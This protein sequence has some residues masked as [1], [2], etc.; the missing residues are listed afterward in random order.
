MSQPISVPT[1][2]PSTSPESQSQSS[3]HGLPSSPPPQHST[4]QSFPATQSS[5]PPVA[6]RL[7]IRAPSASADN[8][9]IKFIWPENDEAARSFAAG[10]P[11]EHASADFSIAPD[12]SFVET[13]SG[14]AAMELKRKYDSELGRNASMKTPYAITAFINQHGRRMFRI[15][16]RDLSAPATAGHTAEDQIINRASSSSSANPHG[17][18]TS[19][20][21]HVSSTTTSSRRRSGRL[22][23]FLRPQQNSNGSSSTTTR[24][25]YYSTKNKNKLRKPRSNPDLQQ[26]Q[27]LQA[28]SPT[29]PTIGLPPYASST[30]PGSM[31]KKST[32]GRTHS[33]SVTAIDRQSPYSHSH[34]PFQVG[35]F[36]YTAPSSSTSASASSSQS[37]FDTLSPPRHPHQS[38][39]GGMQRRGDVFGEV[40]NW[41]LATAGHGYA[42]GRNRDRNNSTTSSMSMAATAGGS[43]MSPSSLSSS[44]SSSRSSV[45][46]AVGEFGEVIQPHDGG[47]RS[48]R[49]GSNATD[50]STSSPQI[51]HSQSS[52]S[53]SQS[54]VIPRPFG[55]NVT[56]EPRWRPKQ[57]HQQHQRGRNSVSNIYRGYGYGDGY[58]TPPPPVP[59]LPSL[60]FGPDAGPS[61]SNGVGIG[62]P[63]SNRTEE[64]RR[65]SQSWSGVGADADSDDMTNNGTGLSKDTGYVSESVSVDGEEEGRE[66]FE[67]WSAY[68]DTHIPGGGQPLSSF[69]TRLNGVGGLG[70][71]GKKKDGDLESDM[72]EVH[73]NGDGG[74]VDDTQGDGTNGKGKAPQ[75]GQD[76]EEESD[77]SIFLRQE[78]MSSR[79]RAMPS[80]DSVMTARQGQG[81]RRRS[82]SENLNFRVRR[83]RVGKVDEG[84]EAYADGE[85]FDEDDDIETPPRPPSAIRMRRPEQDEPPKTDGENQID[86]QNQNQNSPSQAHQ[87]PAIHVQSHSISSSSSTSTSTSTSTPSDSDG[88]SVTIS[89]DLHVDHEFPKTPTPPAAPTA[90]HQVH[91]QPLPTTARHTHFSTEVFDVLQTY[92]GLPLLDRLEKQKSKRRGSRRRRGRPSGASASASSASGAEEEDGDDFEMDGEDGRDVDGDVENEN[93][94][95]DDNDDDGEDE[96]VIKLSLEDDESAAPR[97]DPRFVIWG[98]LHESN[99]DEDDGVRSSSNVSQVAGSTS[100]ASSISVGGGSESVSLPGGGRSRGGSLSKRKVKKELKKKEKEARSRSGSGTAGVGVDGIPL[101]GSS[102]S[103]DHG[104]EPTPAAPTPTSQDDGKEKKKQL[105]AATIERWLAQVTSEFNYDELLVFFLTYRTYISP[106]DLAHLFICRFHW[107]VSDSEYGASGNT[108]PEVKRVVRLRTFVAFKF[109]L[110][111]F[112]VMD[113]MNNRELRVLL[114]K[115][116]NDFVKDPI[117]ERYPDALVSSLFHLTT[118]CYRIDQLQQNIVKKLRKVAKECK[119]AWVP[120]PPK[121]SQASPTEA[122]G[123]GSN[124]TSPGSAASSSLPTPDATEPPGREHL[125]GERF[126]EAALALK[127]TR[128]RKERDEDSDVDLDFVPDHVAATAAG[129]HIQ[130]GPTGIPLSSLSILQ[131]TDL[132]PGP[133]SPDV[134]ASMAQDISYQ[135]LPPLHGNLLSKVMG[136]LGKFKRVLKDHRTMG[137]MTTYGG[138]GGDGSGIAPIGS[139]LRGYPAINIESFSRLAVADSLRSPT[140]H[141]TQQAPGVLVNAPSIST[142]RNTETQAPHTQSSPAAPSVEAQTQDQTQHPISPTTSLSVSVAGNQPSEGSSTEDS[143]SLKVPST[144]R[145][146]DDT[147]SLSSRTSSI[148]LARTSSTDSFGVPLSATRSSAMFPAFRSPWQFDV[149]SLDELSDT[150]SNEDGEHE[151]DPTLPPGL[152][153]AHS[154]FNQHQNRPQRRLP[155]RRIMEVTND[156]RGTVSSMGI[157]SRR[158]HASTASTS[159]IGGEED[160]GPGLGRGIQQWQLN[161]LVDSLTDNEEPGDVEDALKRLEGHINPDKVL[162]KANKVEG[163][164]RTIRDKLQ[165]GDYD[166]DERPRWM[167]EDD[168]EENEHEREQNT[169]A[170]V[171]GEDSAGSAFEQHIDGNGNARVGEGTG[172]EAVKTPVGAVSPPRG[173]VTTDAKPAPEDVVPIEILQSR[174]SDLPSL[175]PNRPSIALRTSLSARHHSFVLDSKADVLAQYFAVIDRDLFCALGFDELLAGDWMS[176]NEIEVYSWKQ[177]MI[178][179]ARWRAESRYPER[180][181][182]LGNIRARFNLVANFAVSEVVHTHPSDRVHVFVKLLHV[183]WRSYHRNNLNN[184]VAIITGLQSTW[185]EQAM[186]RSI[187]RLSSWDARIFRDL[188]LYIANTNCFQYLREAIERIM[189]AKTIDT[190]GHSSSVV[191]GAHVDQSGRNRGSRGTAPSACI[192]FVGIYLSQLYQHHQLP[193]LIDPTAPN[194]AV[195]IDP[196]TSNLEP[197]AHPEVFDALAPLPSSLHL[198]PL[199]NVQKQRLIASVV[200][201][202]IS[203]QQFASRIRFS[204][205]DPNIHKACLELQASDSQTLQRVLHSLPG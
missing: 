18:F 203:G 89:D 69:T 4:S 148:S 120:L 117:L 163:W 66:E 129:L 48:Q 1:P 56:F 79:L 98:E 176:C 108:G 82:S 110:T 187:S 29:R 152:T 195:G 183:A 24:P 45:G 95:N 22:S 57:R 36:L 96:W 166:E 105:L 62:T 15:G 2:G 9:R 188:Q 136:R 84:E 126:A 123:D 55:S 67:L 65:K 80:L 170:E 202:C 43:Y 31:R 130:L 3:P 173:A 26:Q 147:V 162:E 14:A 104:A 124:L 198:E 27:Q 182:A 159:S 50:H 127:K 171:E 54:Q 128:E 161:E 28:T 42:Y 144:P 90:P 204:A 5:P 21:S 134:E 35:S 39:S 186:Q 153:G 132:A 68:F 17:P 113:F 7:P 193:D 149:V 32:G 20:S 179:C 74:S 154:L 88:Q 180:T 11:A 107:A 78:G 191:N 143:G 16:H 99:G 197:P 46:V 181:S 85:D 196:V 100:R 23:M 72:P 102:Q 93:G 115:W 49:S 12:G 37:G 190:T 185:V 13:S 94:V 119:R 151:H 167:D 34:S 140:P 59:S 135:P 200:K 51:Q 53:Q 63:T 145:H 75:Q 103:S 199:I 150:S 40:M 205:D 91:V 189:D 10:F 70:E 156:D 116:L 30:L 125:L 38:P 138:Y 168:D 44:V 61:F 160:A 81:A 194:E 111:T 106:L 8:S 177:Y 146:P 137:R 19:L 77:Y 112:F 47:G 172:V 25:M 175:I 118:C 76:G 133:S 83:R 169:L 174:L 131:R 41:N 184:V 58:R 157:I 114:A 6:I 97:N 101:P 92:R 141:T 201:S 158:S 87:I 60:P 52:Q 73:V 121:K 142:L 178:D 155:T 64:R 71:G 109:W 86:S 33:L 165:A 192:P 164:V 139:D 122:K